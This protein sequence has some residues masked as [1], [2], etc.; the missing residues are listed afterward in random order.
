M[1]TEVNIF[2]IKVKCKSRLI[3]YETMYV[4]EAGLSLYPCGIQA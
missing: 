4:E 2:L 3:M 1:T